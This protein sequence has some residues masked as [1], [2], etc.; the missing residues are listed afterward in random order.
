MPVEA[1]NPE[2]IHYYID[3]HHLVLKFSDKATEAQMVRC[4]AQGMRVGWGQSRI[5]QSLVPDFQGRSPI[6]T[7]VWPL[8][9]KR[10]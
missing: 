9:S 3:N 2:N 5:Y 8:I 10:R 7:H 6:S 1:G 4:L